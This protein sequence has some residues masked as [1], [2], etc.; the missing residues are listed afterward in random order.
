MRE[1]IL[2]KELD[3]VLEQ[4][5]VLWYQK[6]R[7]KWVVLGDRNTKFYHTSTVVSR[8]RNKIEMLKGEDDRWIENPEELEKLAMSYYKRLYSTDDLNLDT[9]KLPQQGFTGF[10]WDEVKSLEESFSEG[11]IE[12]AI[13][14][15]GKYKA[16]GPD[17]FQ[18]VFYQESWDVVGASVIRC[19][20]EFFETGVLTEGMNDVMLVLLPKVLKPERIMQ[21]MPISLCNVLFKIITK[22]M[23]LRLKKLMP[24]LISPSQAS[25]IP[26]RLSSDNIVIVQEA[27]HSMRRKKGRR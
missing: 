13:R 19:G 14:S 25:F 11:E 1:S 12:G 22:T 17:G 6:S 27:V 10:S 5:E 7:E 9:E 16:P 3:I 2:Q 21:F 26:G 4:E 18:P 8:K 23:V 15:M 24:K 20:L